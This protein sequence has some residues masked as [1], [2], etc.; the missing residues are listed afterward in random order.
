MVNLMK[1]EEHD[2]KQNTIQSSPDTSL[3][4]NPL[5]PEESEAIGETRRTPSNTAWKRLVFSNDKSKIIAPVSSNP[6]LRKNQ[7]REESATLDCPEA[8][9]NQKQIPKIEGR[10]TRREQRHA[11]VPANGCLAKLL[12]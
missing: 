7:N 8:S 11:A 12:L 5:K 9:K 2:R 10:G 3:V 6:T 1:W 4:S